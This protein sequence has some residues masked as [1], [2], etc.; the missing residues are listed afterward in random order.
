MPLAICL[1]TKSF[2]VMAPL[3][4]AKAAKDLADRS[5]TWEDRLATLT[6]LPSD[7]AIGLLERTYEDIRLDLLKRLTKSS[8]ENVLKILTSIQCERASLGV[9]LGEVYIATAQFLSTFANPD[10]RIRAFCKQ[11]Y[12]D[13]V[14]IEFALC[15]EH[16]FHRLSCSKRNPSCP[17][18][19]LRPG[20]R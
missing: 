12:K 16:T 4:I 17:C 1:D 6:K 2:S 19:L 14:E 13:G 8:R 7:Q 11:G 3:D 5:K 20:R 15:T 10:T 18:H 9:E